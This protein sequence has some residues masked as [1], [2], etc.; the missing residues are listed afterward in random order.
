MGGEA[1]KN[2]APLFC[3]AYRKSKHNIFSF[4][5]PYEF[6]TVQ[7]GAGAHCLEELTKEIES[8]VSNCK[9]PP[10]I[11]FVCSAAPAGVTHCGT[12][13]HQVT[14]GKDPLLR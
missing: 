6:L 4:L 7:L 2:I 9:Y 1:S 5:G 3:F 10:L 14:G 11:E 12:P 8:L 13:W